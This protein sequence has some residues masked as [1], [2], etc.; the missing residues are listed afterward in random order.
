MK[1]GSAWNAGLASE[2][3]NKKNR[4]GP[5]QGG[6]PSRSERN[7]VALGETDGSAYSG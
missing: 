6:E 5:L 4:D 7:T 1:H 2:K 3:R